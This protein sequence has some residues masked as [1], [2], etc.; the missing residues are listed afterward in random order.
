MISRTCLSRR[1]QR[2]SYVRHA[3]TYCCLVTATVALTPP[4]RA[5]DPE[6]YRIPRF[7]G[8]LIGEAAPP[9]E[10]LSL[11]YRQPAREWVEALAIGNGRLGA[12]VFGG[13]VEEHLQLNED[14]LWAGG[15]YQAANPDAR[16]ALPRV[17]ELVFAGRIEEAQQLASERVLAKP[18]REMPYQPVGSLVLTFP[19][20]DRVED[21]RRELNLDAAVAAVT[22]KVDG[23]THRREVF[24]S[25]VDQLIVIRLSADRPGMIN[26]EAGMTSP[27]DAACTAID[28]HTLALRGVNGAYQNIPGA[29]KFES[30]VRISPENGT[31]SRR[32]DDKLAVKRADAVTIFVSAATSFNRYDDVS[33]DA[34]AR[35]AKAIDAV[36]AKTYDAL[37]RSH[38]AEH[39]RL[40]RRVAL[41]L[42]STDAAK[43][44]T[45]ERIQRFADGG[46]SQLAALYFQF[47]RYLL[48][49]SSR[50]GDQ[51]A[52]LQGIWNWQM[53]PPWECKYTVNINTEMNYW[54]ADLT[55]LAECNEPLFAMIEDLAV[56]G[57]HTAKVM[58]GARG[59][60][61][62]HNTD[63]W[64]ATAPVDQPPSGMWP[65][66]GA[67]LCTHLWD[68]Y[69]F[70]QDRDFL[71][72]HFDAMKGAAEF[73]LD[74]LVEHPDRK[75]LVTCPSVSP[76]NRYGDGKAFCA[77][78]TMDNQIIR[79]L[80]TQTI[81]AGEMLG[82]D[83]E[84]RSQLA[85]ARDRLPP[86]QIGKAGQLQEWLD[87]VDMEVPDIHHRHVSHLYGL[88]PSSQITLRGTPDLAAAVR[89][90]LEIRGDNATGWGI[91]WRI[92]L[93]ARLQ[94]GEHTYGVLERLISP[95]RTYPNMFDAHPPFQIDGNL[96]GAA[97]IAAML[98]Q[99]H[100]GEI[101]LL[102]AL[103]KAWPTGSV[104]GLRARGGFEVDL[105][106]ADGRLTEAIIRST[107]GRQCVVRYDGRVYNFGGMG[108]GSEASITPGPA[109]PH[110]TP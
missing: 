45:D 86:N 9:T 100:A 110:T 77:G 8:E 47:G 98:L 11:W 37:L 97:G 83:A 104:K 6:A 14:T 26:V 43:L 13:I 106:W 34:A 84:L 79:D 20:V 4:T 31:I 69:L 80:F 76:E 54:P 99:S 94:D 36:A 3:T 57:Q 107:G 101:E 38:I 1:S 53:K 62:H 64:R 33:G 61:T 42:G 60:V 24:C 73:F 51:P 48:I 40:F 35:A 66:G 56:S 105:A 70:T 30:R 58:H 72:R 28:D 65:T 102:P 44:P 23:V 46:D 50:P 22:Y 39:Q 93:W 78:P 18:L 91:G 103:P 82:V 87:D 59:W 16:E 27:Q 55:N 75:Y 63:L 19:S 7:R 29:L 10:P 108:P 21:Y 95:G 25:P 81:A 5:Q 109:G 92:N 88:Y 32:G 52:N 17:R 71:A 85:A 2:V 96:G 89:K 90:S 74:T 67:W 15:P 41:D 49:A 68:H 12:M